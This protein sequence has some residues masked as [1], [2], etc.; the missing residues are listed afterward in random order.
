VLDG[1]APIHYGNTTGS[2]I[3]AQD[4]LTAAH[5]TLIVNVGEDVGLTSIVVLTGDGDSRC[6]ESFLS[7][8]HLVLKQ[9]ISTGIQD[10]SRIGDH[11]PNVTYPG[12]FSQ[13]ADVP[14]ASDNSVSP[15]SS[16]CVHCFLPDSIQTNAETIRVTYANIS[17]H[18]MHPKYSRMC[19]H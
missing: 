17:F 3:F 4:Q 12:D 14:G 16:L 18:G 5:H 7:P 11:H 6:A 19:P 1:A 10:E 9:W 2:S 8:L 13:E 15:L